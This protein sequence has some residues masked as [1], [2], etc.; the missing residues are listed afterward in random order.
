MITMKRNVFLFF[1]YHKWKGMGLLI[2]LLALCYHCVDNIKVD[3]DFQRILSTGDA[4][5]TTRITPVFI[6]TK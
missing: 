1:Y 3:L 2:L 4:T 6:H 5:I